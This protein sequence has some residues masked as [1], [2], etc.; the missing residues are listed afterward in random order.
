MKKM[1]F[2]LLSIGVILFALYSCTG[3]NADQQVAAPAPAP[4]EQPVQT[5]AVD[6]TQAQAPAAAT[7]QAVPE[8][9]NAFVKQHFPNATIAGV[10][11]DNDHGGTEYELYLSDGTEVDFDANNQWDNV[12]CHGKA[13]PAALVPQAIATYVKSNYQNIAITKINKEHY[14]YEIELANGLELNFDR[15]GKFTGTDD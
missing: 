7:I 15:S 10:E 9:V 6:S 14:G 5:P 8:A 12:D 11:V 3:N 4:Q 13:V 2:K 1:N